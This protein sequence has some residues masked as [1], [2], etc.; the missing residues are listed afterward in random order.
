MAVW[1]GRWS[2]G[3]LKSCTERVCIMNVR[4]V[5][6]FASNSCI[7]TEPAA[8]VEENVESENTDFR[9]VACLGQAWRNDHHGELS[10]ALYGIA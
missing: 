5:C 1:K 2:I 4:L 6:A 3:W 9:A 7:G 10:S 8:Y